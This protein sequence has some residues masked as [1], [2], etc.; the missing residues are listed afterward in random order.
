[1]KI[2]SPYLLFLGDE[3]SASHAKTAR[4]LAHWR[5][6]L[7]LAQCRVDGKGADLGLRDLSPADA[8]AEGARTMVIGVANVGGF[9]P[10]EWTGSIV[11]ALEAGLDVASGLHTRLTEL[12]AVRDAAARTGQSLYDVRHPQRSFPPGTGEPRSGKRLLTVGTD[13]AVGKMYT[14][15]AL[16]RAMKN[17]GLKADFRATGQTGILIAGEGVSVDAVVSDFVSGATEWLSPA[18]EDDHWDLIEGQGSLFHPAYA[19]VTLGLVHGSQPHALVVCHQ[20]KRRHLHGFPR[21]ETPSIRECME[22]HIEAARLTNPEVVCAGVSIDTS[23]MEEEAASE[24][25]DE[26]EDML[27]VPCVDPLKTGVQAIVDRLEDL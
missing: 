19:G 17:R 14:A 20:A 9:I 12:A 15:L 23:S 2:H 1:V 22:R 8:A 11:G 10:E 5:P 4:G 21:Y 6:E 24:Y 3:L 18:N 13:C 27:D 25:L 16:E 7:C 26:I